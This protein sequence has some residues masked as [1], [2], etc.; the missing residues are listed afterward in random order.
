MYI[1]INMEM[2]NTDIF[3]HITGFI[4]IKDFQYKKVIIQTM[5][6]I[7]I[8][9]SILL[10]SQTIWAQ[11][12]PV[13]LK[14]TIIIDT[15]CAIDDMRAISLLLSRPEITIK[16]ILLSDGSLSP[17]GGAGKVSS[18]LK[19]FNVDNIPVACG[20]LL[21]G[22]NPPW[23]EFNSQIRWGSNESGNQEPRLN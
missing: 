15:D 3:I 8:L 19:E 1:S 6:K 7:Y 18:L 11:P 12:L 2:R 5:R 21:K 16:A 20:D 13:K 22:V 14:H 4:N 9:I 10:L 17:I 23:R